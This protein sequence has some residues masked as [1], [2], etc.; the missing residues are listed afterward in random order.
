MAV[1]NDINTL[2]LN[3]PRL[4]SNRKTVIE[5][6]RNILIKDDKRNTLVRLYELATVGQN[7]I[8][9]SYAQVAQ[10]Y[11]EKKQRAHGITPTL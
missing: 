5:K 9:E 7:G 11:L 8:L 3:H 4:M 6:L 2:N 1:L 10:L